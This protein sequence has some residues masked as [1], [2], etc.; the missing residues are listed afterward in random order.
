VTRR[1]PIALDRAVISFTFDDIAASAA[2]S[3]A[4]VL[5]TRGVRGTFYVCGGL[6]GSDWDLYPLAGLDAVAGLARR[7]HE[8]GCH[9]ATHPS[10]V[11]VSAATYL[12]DVEANARILEPVVGRRLDTFAYPFGAIG[13]PHKRALQE[14]FRACRG[15][16]GGPITRWADRGRLQAVALEDATIGEAGID[17]LLDAA[18]ARQAWLVFYAHDVTYRPTR[19]GV[20]PDRLAYAVDGALA[21][22]CRIETVAGFLDHAE[23]PAIVAPE[24]RRAAG[25][26]F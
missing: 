5:E 6:A 15:I 19:F 25:A 18:V 12:R 8:I 7:S 1:I 4:Q 10:G 2:Q 17:A 23:R 3:G 22:G 16:H 20:S 24:S 14:K 9:T 13:L 26:R 21:R 11:K